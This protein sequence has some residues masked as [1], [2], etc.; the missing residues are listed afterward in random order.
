MDKKDTIKSI[1]PLNETPNEDVADVMNDPDS[2]KDEESS[3]MTIVKVAI[4]VVIVC[5]FV[6]LIM[7]IVKL[8]KKNDAANA[9]LN[10]HKEIIQKQDRDL[11][12]SM[13]Y[14]ADLKN[15]IKKVPTTTEVPQIK[16]RIEKMQQRQAQRETKA[17]EDVESGE[18]VSLDDEMRKS[19]IISEAIFGGGTIT[20]EN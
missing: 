20:E 1:N 7:S 10:K 2:S 11:N 19:E 6:L 13:N 15:S 14:I 16:T 17:V 18:A 9:E 8:K 3:F 4:A 5:L 12:E